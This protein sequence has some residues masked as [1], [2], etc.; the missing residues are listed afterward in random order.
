MPTN[1]Y[2]VQPIFYGRLIKGGITY[3]TDEKKNNFKVAE[4][5][6][7]PKE[8]IINAQKQDAPTLY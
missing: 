2:S 4:N 6:K 8:W 1:I 3:A 5:K 7:K